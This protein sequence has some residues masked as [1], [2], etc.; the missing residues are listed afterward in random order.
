MDLELT[1]KVAVITGTAHGIGRETARQLLA[2]GAIVV[3][4]DVEPQD[5]D[6]LGHNFTPVQ[7]D[8]VDPEAPQHIMNLTLE[9]FGRVD[10]LVNNVGATRLYPG[11]LEIPESQ[12][13][14]GFEVNFHSARRMTRAAL[15]TMLEQGSGSIIFLA[16]D[17]ARYP[18]PQELHYSVAK[19]S[20]LNFSKGLAMEFSPRGVRSNV[21]SPGPTRT[22]MYDAPGG[23]GDQAAAALQMEKEAAIEFIFTNMRKIPT[24]RLGRAEDVAPV[25]SYLLSPLASQ[26][27][28]DEWSINGGDL[29][30]I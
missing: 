30:Q 11:F 4:A 9:R 28:G 6:G 14:D 27:T 7:V 3:G 13:M 12:W 10:G 26:V 18:A 15:P 25:I 17:A 20:L 23:W 19:S 29:P 8:L 21:V 1:G 2:E 16:T 22:W 24:G 5:E